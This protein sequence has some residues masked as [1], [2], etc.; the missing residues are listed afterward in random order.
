MRLIRDARH[1][2]CTMLPTPIGASF[3]TGGEFAFKYILQL[4]QKR[5]EN[6]PTEEC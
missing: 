4:R 6:V 2:P 5:N 3:I 1:T